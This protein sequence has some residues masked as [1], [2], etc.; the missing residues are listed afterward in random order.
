M[1]LKKTEIDVTQAMNYGFAFVFLFF[2]IISNLFYAKFRKQ[3]GIG[4]GDIKLLVWMAVV[5][6]ELVI[7][8]FF[9]SAVVSGTCLRRDHRL[10]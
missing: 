6:K 8:V 1:L 7:G 10:R 4:W 9:V 5:L 3:D 2:L